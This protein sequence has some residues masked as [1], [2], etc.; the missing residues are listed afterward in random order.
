MENEPELADSEETEESDD[1][2][3]APGP[4]QIRERIL[5]SREVLEDRSGS[6]QA[7]VQY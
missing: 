4:T 2:T 3:P 6:P 1:D 5:V 7:S